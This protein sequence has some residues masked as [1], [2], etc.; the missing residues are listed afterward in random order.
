MTRAGDWIV[1]FDLADGYYT[2]GIREE[3]I[4]FFTVNYCGTLYRLAGLAM[5]WKCSSYYFA[6]FTEVLSVTYANHCPTPPD[7]PLG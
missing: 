7:T 2:L 6:G 4:D 3:D 1:S 5:G